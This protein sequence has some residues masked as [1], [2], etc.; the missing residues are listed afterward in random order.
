VN[1]MRAFPVVFAML[2]LACAQQPARPS[3]G[4]SGGPVRPQATASQPSRT[5]RVVIRSEPGSVAG[6]ILIPT[7]I[8]TENQRRIFNASLALLDGDSKPRPYLADSLPALNS[9]SWRV[10]ADGTMETTFHLKPNLTWQD[11]TPLTADDFVFA[12]QVYANKNY[13]LAGTVPHSV[14]SEVVAP[15][16]QT[17]QIRWKEPYPNAAEMDLEAF[18]PLPRHLLQASFER[19]PEN[20]PNLPFWTSDFV[21]AGPYRVDNWQ[22]GAFIDAAAFDGHA[23]G[24]PKI[25]R[26]KIT[27]SADF[28]ATLASLVSGDEDMP[29][30]DS[31][32]VDQ[33]LVLEQDWTARNAGTVQYRPNLP[34]FVQVQHR[35]EYANPAVV[36]DARVRKALAHA[37]DKSVIND[38]LFSGK[39]ITTDTL[40]YPTLD[41]YAVVDAKAVKY[42]FDLR[43]SEQ[44]MNEAG[45][46]KDA[47]G[48]YT[49]P[50]G[51]RINLEVRNIQSAQNDAERS[52]IADGWRKA[53]F[54]VEENVFTPVQTQDGQVLG[55]FR[56]LSITSAAAVHEG[57]DVGALTTNSV[58]RPETHWFGQNRGGWSNPDF[59]RAATAFATTLDPDARH[60]ALADAIHALTDD[61]G[62]IPLHFNPGVIAWAAGMQGV[63]VKAPDAVVSWNI[64]EWTFR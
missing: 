51:G 12:R 20:L 4:P 25:D 47:S 36:R 31:I 35:A 57:E 45:L 64:H 63:S 17:V 16:P 59:D 38:T 7:G 14:M 32:R 50:G 3:S 40:I 58:S 44:L 15:D 52:I 37:I 21:G 41:Y 54:E 61:L 19:E 55:T 1:W 5:L 56:S 8:T 10:A 22:P 60:Q 18:A 6:T 42:P 62:V 49:L 24:K 29:L 2:I 39:G 28:N 23:L 27:W 11:G 48:A 43:A 34:R 9:D 13:G 26:L 30:D 53:G 33:G 46:S